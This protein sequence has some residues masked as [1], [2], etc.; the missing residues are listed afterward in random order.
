MAEKYARLFAASPDLY[1]A[2]KALL[3]HY[4]L[5]VESGDAGNWDAEREPQVIAA[6]AAL[7]KVEGQS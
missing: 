1:E 6:R 3:D 4:T 2:L 5:M 7:A